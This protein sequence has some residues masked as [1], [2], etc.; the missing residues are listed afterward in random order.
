VACCT[1]LTQSSLFIEVKK[2]YLMQAFIES[3]KK[4]QTIRLIM[5]TFLAA[6]LLLTT[7]CS[8]GN[9]VGARPR[10]PPVQMGGQ[11][12]PHKGGGDGYTQY[13][14]DPKPVQDTAG[15]QQSFKTESDHPAEFG[16]NS[17]A[18]PN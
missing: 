10:N 12:N 1:G 6:I 3:L 17:R 13:N 4:L 15:T 9:E 16:A 7:A 8:T 18:T 5:A 11:N 2:E 14:T